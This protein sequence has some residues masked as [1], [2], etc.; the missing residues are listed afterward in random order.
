M[1][2]LIIGVFIIG[3]VLI[4]LEH[5]LHIDKAATATLIGTISWFILF[6]VPLVTQGSIPHHIQHSLLH[7]V[8]EAASILF[9]LLGA[10]TIVE[11]IDS[12][13]GFQYILR[14][15]RVHQVGVF[16]GI[17]TTITFFLSAVI[18][19]LTATLL[20]VSLL[21]KVISPEQRSSRLLGASLVVLAANSG[22]AWSP[23]GDITTTMLWIK[24]CIT[25]K[26]I[27][28][29]TFIPSLLSVVLPYLIIFSK[30]R[31]ASI[32]IKSYNGENF[33]VPRQVSLVVLIFGIGGILAVPLMKI[34][35]HVPPFLAMLL[36]LGGVWL[37]TEVFYRRLRRKL[38]EPNRLRVAAALERIDTP[39][40]LFF[41]G[42][43]LAIGALG[44]IGAL[45]G[46]AQL[47]DRWIGNLDAVVFLLGIL[48][49]VVDNVPLV[50]AA[51][52]MYPLSE[53]PVDHR[54]WEFL[55]Y[56]AGVGGNLL[57]IG[58]AAGV[59]A[60]GMEN[61]EFFWY[62]RRVSWIAFIGYSVGAL[63]Y[64]LLV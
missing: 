45:R 5:R 42:I 63:A 32:E 11:V 29:R 60:M 53:F 12:Y 20:M 37:L 43:L 27:I 52:E 39:S 21:Q 59:I 50:A 18:D 47:L 23:L 48:S 15:L 44:E 41:L 46:L 36:S 33:I 24:G 3:Y 58:S 57:I 54:L 34:F 61:I 16:L 22:G 49:A 17:S 4:A 28:Q 1:E 19:N 14:L 51:I 26:V 64:I 25:E 62:L 6:G 10:M 31:S 40:L 56:A 9:F 30:L 38:E 8:S 7:H 35:L 55:A 2:I 13:D